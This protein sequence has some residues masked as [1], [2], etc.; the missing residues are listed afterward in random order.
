M[1][2]PCWLVELRLLT[3]GERFRAPVAVLA[4]IL[5]G[6]PAVRTTVAAADYVLA[7]PIV[8]L[9]RAV[10]ASSAVLGA[11]DSLAGATSTAAV[12]TSD[13]PFP[14]KIDAGQPFKMVLSVSGTAVSFA[15]SWD[16][17]NTLPPGLTVEGAVL[18]GGIWVINDANPTKGILTIS[19]T[20]TTPGVY[21]LVAHAWQ[22]TYR[23]GSVTSGLSTITVNAVVG[24][25]PALTSQ[26]VSQSV[27]EDARVTFS[28]TATGYPTPSYQWRKDGQ[29]L[30]GATSSSFALAA[31]LVADSGSYTVVVSN[32]TGSVTSNAAALTV[33]AV[34][35]VQTLTGQPCALT[36]LA[37]SS[38]S[39]KVGAGGTP[40]LTYQWYKNGT[41][42]SGATATTYTIG[43][44]AVADAGSYTVVVSNSSGS[45]TS[46]AAALTVDAFATAPVLTS[47][48]SAQAVTAGGSVSFTVAAAGTAPLAYQWRREG[49][50]ISG[51]TAA[52]Y[53]IAAAAAGDAGSY[54]VVVSN[55]QGSVTSSAA[56][57]TVNAS[58]VSP[59]I[60]SHPNSLAVTAG[61]STS[62]TVG[63][64]G[65]AP[66]TYQ[67]YKNGSAL[68]GATAA[69]YLI[70]ATAVADAGSYTVTVVNAAGSAT[71]HAATLTVSAAAPGDVPTRLTNLSVRTG[72]GTGDS[73]LIVGLVVGGAGTGGSK[74][75][76]LRAVGPTLA[77][78][79]VTGTLTDPN[80]DFIPQG[81]ATPL[82]TDDNWA[83]DAQIS[84]VANA[85]GAFP[86]VSPTSK[87]AALSLTPASGVYSVKV[88]GV[89]GT[90]GITL[91][92]IYDA[93]GTA[94]TASTP[95]LIN[96]SARAQVGTGD[97]VLIAGFVIDGT[98]SRTVLIRAVGPTLGA[99]GV[100]G[101][102]ADPQLE[103]THTVSGATVVVASNDNWGGDATISSVASA[104]GA[105]ALSSANSQ[106]AAILVTLPPGVYSA[107][108]SGTGS[109]TGVALI[110]VYEVP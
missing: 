18:T 91:A 46:G 64:S 21:S 75:L 30:A 42:I 48:P 79:G 100:G 4:A 96:V 88:T 33:T 55:A 76:L 32:S 27:Y 60:S 20:P 103:L 2:F 54:T 70:P 71:S 105:F 19:G 99:Y 95:R 57:L 59:A 77:S 58:I 7:S 84:S 97:G 87:D 13:I 25:V 73:T 80:L 26:P 74:P 92:E 43:T 56:L 47:Q 104:V 34:N 9:L 5:H 14:A 101:A 11:Y 15:Q 10:V 41:A 85:L 36:V 49:Q 6:T 81:A 108:A 110:E 23:S 86:M 52:T 39:L 83:G 109:T 102:L 24:T 68:G 45:V 22:G 51:A 61:S 35:R 16:V 53:T 1:N 12:L 94:F 62:L 106:D 98:A 28:V 90:T 69:T 31:A 93:S 63:A 107:K 38:L 67:W 72:A 78:Y 89:G 65:T 50:A 8:A 82:A 3:R 66:L 29:P 44:V 40:P 37:G 17:N